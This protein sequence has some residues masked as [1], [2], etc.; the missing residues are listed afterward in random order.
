MLQG[1]RNS[2]SSSSSEESTNGL[3]GLVSKASREVSG[4]CTYFEKF[5]LMQVK[6]KKYVANL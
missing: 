1:N 6:G 5:V 3:K 4:E 2:E